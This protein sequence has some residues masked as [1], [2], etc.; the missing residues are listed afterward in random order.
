MRAPDRERVGV[1]EDVAP[2]LKPPLSFSGGRMVSSTL[3]ESIQENI[4]LI[5]HNQVQGIAKPEGVAADP[6]YGA[7]LPH[8]EFKRGRAQDVVRAIRNAIRKLEDRLEDRSV[9]VE[10]ASRKPGRYFPFSRVRISGNILAT[11][12]AVSM[13]F[14]IEE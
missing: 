6:D 2:Y 11:G 3:E 7:S 1:R 10:Y 14:D 4:R 13:E 9:K 5:L 12:E 8:H